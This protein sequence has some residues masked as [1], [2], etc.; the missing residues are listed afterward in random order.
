LFAPRRIDAI[1][2]EGRSEVNTDDQFKRIYMCGSMRSGTT[3]LHRVV[4]LSED[5]SKFNAGARYLM[6]QLQLYVRFSGDDK[7][8]IDDYFHDPEGFKTFVRHIVDE[9]AHSAWVAA[10][11]PKC[12]V[13]KSPE[14]SF[15]LPGV[16]DIL[17]D[18]AI[19]IFSVRDPKDTIASM[20]TAGERQRSRGL[21]TMLSY[22]GR[23]IDRLCSVYN[24]AYLPIIEFMGKGKEELRNRIL[25]SRYEDLVREPK[26]AAE[27]LYSFCGVRSAVI[28]RRGDWRETKN[29]KQFARHPRWGTY[30]TPLSSGGISIQSIGNYR[31]ILTEKECERINKNC[32]D[33]VDKFKY[34]DNK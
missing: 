6:E 3:L 26:T 11:K 12:V 29:V 5:V 18:S 19:F 13:F 28:P 2:P 24:R 30:V 1:T 25:F 23:D 31:K 34:R 4:S 16:I 20:I 9:I 32:S 22:L 17:G 8:Y 14:L 7:L 15:M 33:L 27:A 21:S 10:N